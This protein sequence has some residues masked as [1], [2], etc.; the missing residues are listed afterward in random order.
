MRL[1]AIAPGGKPGD[2]VGV[3]PL[4]ETARLFSESERATQ[5]VNRGSLH[6]QVVRHL[7]DRGVRLSERGM[8]ALLDRLRSGG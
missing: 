8:A 1:H 3:E 6:V 4:A 7:T 5:T 2:E